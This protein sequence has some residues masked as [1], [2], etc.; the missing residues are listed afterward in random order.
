[1]FSRKIWFSKTTKSTAFQKVTYRKNLP[2]SVKKV[3][4]LWCLFHFKTLTILNSTFDNRT[5][6]FHTEIKI[7]FKTETK[8]LKA[9][10]SFLEHPLLIK[11]RSFDKLTFVATNYKSRQTLLL[12]AYLT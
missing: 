9:T 3:F 7:D 11:I 1:M 12:E 4:Y 6:K 10:Y 2:I 5:S 8:F